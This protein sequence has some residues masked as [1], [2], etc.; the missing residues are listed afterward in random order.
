MN[1]CDVISKLEYEVFGKYTHPTRF[2]QTIE[3]ESDRSHAPREGEAISEDQK[4]TSTVASKV[5]AGLQKLETTKR[6]KAL[7]LWVNL[8]LDNDDK[9]SQNDEQFP[10]RTG[11]KSTVVSTRGDTSLVSALYDTDTEHE[12]VT[13]GEAE[14]SLFG[15]KPSRSSTHAR[16]VS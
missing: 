11:D 4:H 8:S 12:T 10:W 5:R 1:L 16:M 6:Y 13:H 7:E 9:T 3:I 15:P 2:R 14:F